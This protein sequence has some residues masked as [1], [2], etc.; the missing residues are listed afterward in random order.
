MHTYYMQCILVLVFVTEE[1]LLKKCQNSYYWDWDSAT[2]TC[3]KRYATNFY[4]KP[5][6]SID[7]SRKVCT[8]SSFVN[9]IFMLR[10]SNTLLNPR[11]N[12]NNKST[13]GKWHVH[14]LAKQQWSFSATR[15]HRCGQKQSYPAVT[16]AWQTIRS[17]AFMSGN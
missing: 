17:I 4:T 13:L 10:S 11:H 14:T 1:H 12:N 8:A 5:H 15:L 6:N 3:R 2:G 16:A 9:G 7:N